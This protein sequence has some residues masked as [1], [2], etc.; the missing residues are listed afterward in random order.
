MRKFIILSA[1]VLSAGMAQAQQTDVTQYVDPTIG[2]VSILL[3]PVRPTTHLPNQLV[4]WTPTRADMLDDQVSDYPLTMASH[5]RGSLFGFMPLTGDYAPAMFTAKQVW[6]HETC[7]PW[8]YQATLDGCR[9]AMA[10]SRKSGIIRVNFTTADSCWLRLRTIG[11]KGGYDLQDESTIVGT[12]HF[13]GMTAWVAIKLDHKV[14]TTHFKP[15]QKQPHSDAL[16][17]VGKGPATVHLRY[18]VS[19]ISQAQAFDNLRREIPSFDFTSIENQAKDEWRRALS[20]IRTSGGTEVERRV[21]YTALYRC[22]ERM[23]DTNEYGQY[24]S[25]YDHKV[26][27]SDAPFYVDNW[28]WDT[29]IALEPLQTILHPDMEEQ[30]ITSYIDMYRQSGTMPSFA[31][32]SGDWAA[33]T[34]NYAA[35]WMADAWFKGLRFDLKTAYEGLRKNSLERTLLPWRNGKC[36]V[37]DSFYNT[38][39]YFPALKPGEKETVPQVSLP[40]ERRQAVSVTTA[41]SYSD[42]CIA[43]LARELK[44]KDD[45]RLFMQRASFWRNLW[46]PDNGF[47]WP[48]DAQGNWIKGVDPRYADRA[49]YTENN[50]YTFLWDV[51]HDLRGLFGLMGGRKRAEQRLDSLFRIPIGMSK[52]KFWVIL[53]DE[54][55]MVGQFSMGNE[56]SFHIPYLYNYTGSPWKT[57]KRVRMLLHSFF[58][59]DYYGM[60]GDEDGGGMSAFVVFSM[61]GFFPVTPGIPVYTIGSPVFSDITIDLPSGKKFRVKATGCST[62]NKYIQSARLNGKHITRTWFTHREL[63]DGGTLELQMGLNPNR[64]WGTDPDDAP[65]SDINFINKQ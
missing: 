30:K 6:D 14:G 47:I 48:K 25:A 64:K 18:A 40:W 29:H 61:M 42:W 41:N 21:F 16:L 10:P 28:I 55:G 36:C 7:R 27:K 46:C 9:I 3:Q 2:G 57:Q 33:M 43:Q 53:P 19:F 8:T 65:P 12:T 22:Y 23:V 56:P 59:D 51:K 5:R 32:T 50:A 38:H 58:T 60:P 62:E 44:R 37:L 20:C 17:C 26:H 11:G 13:Q 49:Y 54:T 1:F 15:R 63:T 31:T 4:R 34:G 35:T 24:Y 52:Q 39:G 45:T